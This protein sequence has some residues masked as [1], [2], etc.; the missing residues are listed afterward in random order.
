VRGGRDN[1]GDKEILHGETADHILA[2]RVLLSPCRSID[3]GS[4]ESPNAWFEETDASRGV[5]ASDLHDEHQTESM[6]A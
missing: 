6:I 5:G 3:L 2:Q 1:L 4:V